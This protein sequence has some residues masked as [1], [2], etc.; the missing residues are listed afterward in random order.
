MTT[1]PTQRTVQNSILAEYQRNPQKEKALAT[2]PEEAVALLLQGAINK[3][4]LAIE[5]HNTRSFT[6]KGFHIG[7]MTSIVDALR[8]RLNFNFKIGYDLETLYYYVDLCLQESVYEVGTDKLEAAIQI[9]EEIQTAWSISIEDAL[10]KT[11]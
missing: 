4:N 11:A 3:G 7:R 9:L 5:C 6:E 2:N 1:Q 8:E 10:A